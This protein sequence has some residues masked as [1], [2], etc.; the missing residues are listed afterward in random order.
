MQ[1]NIDMTIK[2]IINKEYD[3]IIRKYNRLLKT[4]E[5][6]KKRLQISRDKE[7]KAQRQIVNLKGL[8]HADVTVLT[9]RLNQECSQSKIF[10]S[11]R[12]RLT[13]WLY[14]NNLAVLYKFYAWHD[15]NPMDADNQPKAFKELKEV[16]NLQ[17]QYDKVVRQ[18]EHRANMI[19]Q[20]T[21]FLDTKKLYGE[22]KKWA[23]S[24]YLKDLFPTR[25]ESI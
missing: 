12:D 15:A 24:K 6:A 22:C 10:L 20:F 4:Y 1:I 11:E 21:E 9:D 5:T 16:I 19:A 13:D 17:Y 14:I 18:S 2:E 23:G 25:G 3:L 7:Y 8:V